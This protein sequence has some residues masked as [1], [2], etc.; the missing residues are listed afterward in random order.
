[1]ILFTRSE[2]L[3]ETRN[4]PGAEVERA[5]HATPQSHLPPASCGGN[6]RHRDT[7]RGLDDATESPAVSSPLIA[8]G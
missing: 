3:Q 4:N 6:L 2:G 8:K 5:L 7:P 1:M